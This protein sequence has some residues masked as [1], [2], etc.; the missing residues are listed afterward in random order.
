MPLKRQYSLDDTR[1]AIDR[2]DNRHINALKLVRSDVSVQDWGKTDI[3]V[4]DRNSASPD[5]FPGQKDVGHVFRHIAGKGT[6]G[7]S[8]Y[9]DRNTAVAVTRDLLNSTR[10]QAALGRLEAEARALYDNTMTSVT[11]AI[12]GVYYGSDDDGE[13]W[14]RIEQAKCQLQKL[15]DLLWVHTSYPTALAGT[16]INYLAA[17][18]NMRRVAMGYDF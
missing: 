11:V 4:K 5:P 7:K 3:K 12:T 2:A 14:Q 15:G 1:A 17:N 16:G 8:I 6:P 9:I 10:G 13:T 18:L